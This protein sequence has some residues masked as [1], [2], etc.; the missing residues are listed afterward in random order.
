MP[1]SPDYMTYGPSPEDLEEDAVERL[2]ADLWRADNPTQNVFNCDAETKQ[3]YRKRALSLVGPTGGQLMDLGD[4]ISKDQAERAAYRK[5]WAG[6]YDGTTCPNCNRVRM[7]K[8]TNGKRRCE[9]AT[10]TVHACES[11]E[12]RD[13][14]P[15]D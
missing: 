5:A 1:V 13:N 11:S 9:K 6:D 12:S 8:C 14:G 15:K 3:A 2:A 7:M 10:W 4:H